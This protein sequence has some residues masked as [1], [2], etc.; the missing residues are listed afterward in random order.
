MANYIPYNL[1]QNTMVVINFADQLQSGTFE[2]ALAYLIDRKIDLSRFDEGVS[3]DGGGRRA[4]DPAILLKIILFAYSKGITSSREI[5]WC[6]ETNIIFKALSCDSVPHFTTIASFVRNHS[7]AIEDLFSQVVLICEQEGLIGREL[8]AIDGCKL[9]S[10]A[11]KEWSGTFKEL[12]QKRDKIKRLIQHHLQEDKAQKD[13][14]TRDEK[15]EQRSQQAVE[16]LNKAFDKIDHFLKTQSPRMGQAQRPK[17]VKSNI[18]DNESAKMKTSKGTVQGYN[19]IATVDKKHQVIVDAQAFGEGQEYHTLKPILSATRER[20][21]QLG[22][23]RDIYKAGTIVTA[24]TGF[25]NEANMAMLFNDKI[26]AYVPDSKFRE[27]DT[28]FTYQK[29]KHGKRHQDKPKRDRQKAVIPSTEFAFDPVTETC[30]CPTGQT[31]S[32]RGKRVTDSGRTKVYFEGRL[33][34]CS[35]CKKKNDCMRRPESA[36]HRKGNG[37]Q[38][39]FLVSDKPTYTDWMKARVD[40]DKGKHIYSHRMS[41]VEPVFGNITVNKK[42]N[43]FSLRGKQKVND[44]WRLYCLVHNIEKLANYGEMAA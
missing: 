34:Q 38:V 16:T 15:R 3:N 11:A 25:A 37:R 19:G 18:T 40:S 39:S 35:A 6:C 42:L 13:Q 7:D 23:E 9:S 8:F 27:R 29:E 32:H 24:D 4:Y 21:N 36:N 10:N 5:M 26:D 14:H 28:R 22:I 31:L 12:E 33:S 20:F 44:Q 41:V 43:R 2:Y 30:V 1:N 17:E